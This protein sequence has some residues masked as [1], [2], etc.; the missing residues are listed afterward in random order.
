LSDERER[1]GVPGRGR[2]IKKKIALLAAIAAAVVFL[3][4]AGIADYLT[5]ESVKE[6]RDMM[7][8]FVAGNYALSVMLYIGLFISTA[9][10]I[11]GALILT[12]TGGFLFGTT[13]GS[14]YSSIGGSS[15]ATLA[16]LAARHIAGAGIQDRY[17]VLLKKFNEELAKNGYLYLFILR[18]I[19]VL[20]FFLVNML[21]GLTRIPYRTFLIMTFLGMLPGAA[22]YSFV[23]KQ[24]GAINSFEDL[25]SGNIVTALVLLTLFAFLPLLYRHAAK[26]KAKG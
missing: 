14:L 3:R 5:F 17:A 2:L 22:V 11:P 26:R 18:V 23:G 9:F 6:N 12:V 19:P 8:A 25:F 7:R 21:A 16:F 10:F 24:F 15:G 1:S 20:P 13:L 4:L